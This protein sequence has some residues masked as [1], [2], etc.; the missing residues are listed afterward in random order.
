M[1]KIN[2]VYT[3]SRY[4]TSDSISNSDSKL[5]IKERLDQSDNTVCYIDDVSIPHTWYTM[6]TYNDQLYIETTNNSI[7]NKCY[8]NNST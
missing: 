7:R 4:N 2:K 1:C 3:D 8:G 6:E 5:E